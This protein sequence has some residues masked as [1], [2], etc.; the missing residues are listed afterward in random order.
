M[1]VEQLVADEQKIVGFMPL[2]NGRPFNP[3]NPDRREI[4][5]QVIAHA[6]AR[7]CRF[8]G[9]TLV[10]DS[11][12]QHMVL[13]SVEMERAAIARG[14]SRLQAVIAGMWGLVHD[15]SE[16]LGLPDMS[17]MVKR[18]PQ[19]TAYRDL[20]RPLQQLVYECFG[21]FG[22]EPED[23]HVHDLRVGA[24]EA[25]DFLE[26]GIPPWWPAEYHDTRNHLTETLHS[27]PFEVAK[28]KFLA[29]YAYLESRLNTS[30]PADSFSGV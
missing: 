7:N 4:K 28:A 29:R 6:A 16:C 18:S 26:G 30:T 19:M 8:N 21:L 5:I 20:E 14:E 11:L 24:T 10:H 17:R 13:V 27:W 25:R 1:N 12:G 23:L 15:G 3:I 22:P 9:Q 2:A